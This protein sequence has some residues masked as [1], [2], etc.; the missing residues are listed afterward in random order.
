MTSRISNKQIQEST[1]SYI[2]KNRVE[3]NK[4]Q[5]QVST[6]LKVQKPGDDPGAAG[7]ISL[8]QLQVGRN[9]EHSK[10]I[11]N[12]RSLM[13]FQEDVISQANNVLVRAKEIA[14]QG[15][16]ETYSAEVRAQLAEEVFQLRDQM[17]SLGNSQ[18]Q[19]R[20]IYGGLDDDDP[21]Y[22]AATY[23]EPSSGSAASRYIFDSEDGTSTGKT[24]GISDNLTITA[25]TPGSQI[26]DEGIYAL[27]TL[28]RALAG[29]STTLSGTQPT[30]AGT[31][32]VF[33]DE[34][35]Q[36][37]A[38]IQSSIDALDTARTSYVSPEQAK[39]AGR[40]ARLDSAK[41][42][43]DTTNLSATEVLNKLQNADVFDA[44]SRLSQ[45]QNALEAS[46]AIS[47]RILNTSV[48]DYL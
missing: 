15:A 13:S 38:D 14:T 46:L 9:I 26:F 42:L 4:L 48:L 27:E 18:Y 20:Y 43:L 5:Q 1:L 34:Y 31:A 39:L 23:T 30:G 8:L 29:Y 47:A 11:E 33:P 2:T 32:Y 45:A 21:P 3:T 35:D 28:G 17:V 10:R 41:S 16:N 6:G 36:Q 44:V 7:A 40:L 12:V 19:G 25:T 22:D 24:I 37:T